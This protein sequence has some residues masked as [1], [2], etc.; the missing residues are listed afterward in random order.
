[1]INHYL[2]NGYE[3][4]QYV[5]RDKKKR[6]SEGGTGEEE[7]DA[8]ATSGKLRCMGRGDREDAALMRE[9]E[10]DVRN[11]QTVWAREEALSR[12]LKGS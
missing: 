7:K 3:I 9:R 6:K 11:M 4:S 10:K 5:F 12:V 8:S 1:M 2:L